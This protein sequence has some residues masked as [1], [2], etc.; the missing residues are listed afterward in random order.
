MP[1]YQ[2]AK[3]Y[4]I[5]SFKTD[6]I[7]IG[8]TT[9]PLCKRMVEHRL[10]YKGWLK[11]TKKNCTSFEI[12]KYGDAYIELIKKHPCNSREELNKEEGNHQREMERDKLIK[13]Y[14]TNMQL[15]IQHI[16]KNKDKEHIDDI[17]LKW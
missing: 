16:A 4:C 3:I 2:N 8:S 12:M 17:E 10:K 5:R 6:D 11:G 9:Q 15:I 14:N 1:N 13:K 7:Y